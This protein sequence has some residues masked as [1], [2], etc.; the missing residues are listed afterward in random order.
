MR[1]F[2]L[3]TSPSRLI[4]TSVLLCALVIMAAASVYTYRAYQS[5]ASDL[6]VER[7]RQLVYLTAARVGEDFVHLADEL[8]RVAL[9][10]DDVAS[11]EGPQRPALAMARGRL[12]QFDG[13]AILLDESGRV[14]ATDPPR[15]D[16]NGQDWSERPFFGQLSVRQRVYVSDATHDGPGGADVV[17]LS[18]PV[19]GHDGELAG[20]VVGLLLVGSVSTNDLLSGMLRQSV[21]DTS[22]ARLIDG[23]RRVI[24]DSANRRDGDPP[25]MT[26]LPIGVSGT[27]GAQRSRNE[28]GRDVVSAHA[29]IPGT[30]WTLVVVDDWSTLSATARGYANRLLGLLA[31][32]I[33]AAPMTVALIVRDQQKEARLNEMHAQE[34]RVASMIQ[35][36]MLPRQAPT[37]S[38]WDLA[39]GHTP[40]PCGRRAF[41]DYLFRPDGHLALTIGEISERGLMAAHIISTVRATLRGAAQRELAPHDAL[42]CS[43]ALLCPEIRDGMSLRC[44]YAVFSPQAG[45]V[46]YASAAVDAPYPLAA[47]SQAAAGEPD[48]PLGLTLTS[49][50]TERQVTVQPGEQLVLYTS[51]LTGCRSAQGEAF[52]LDRLGSILER[53]GLTAQQTVDALVGAV[54]AFAGPKNCL[55]NDFVVVVLQ[56]LNGGSAG[57]AQAA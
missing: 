26:V 50:Y 12:G 16:L 38:G 2:G 53:D 36:M 30:A 37:L 19:A 22:E 1:T 44:L 33:I 39:V 35:E 40:A 42:E 54:E 48:A 14:I 49:H 18:V 5:A 41:H 47:G 7:D 43:N 4:V 57:Q 11:T 46:R 20:A 13:G 45:L 52:G 17:A 29:V 6:I 8:A 31:F 51:G 25:R 10:V 24:F 27:L 28:D 21:A 32:G 23:S 34:T 56:R 9:S 15:P 55:Q 3:P